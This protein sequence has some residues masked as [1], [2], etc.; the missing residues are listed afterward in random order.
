MAASSSA[1]RACAHTSDARRQIG[2]QLALIASSAAL[3]Y[4]CR[5]SFPDRM[6][7]YDVTI[8]GNMLIFLPARTCRSIAA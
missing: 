8:D 1:F 5:S 7:R 2:D 6:G 4:R 3:P